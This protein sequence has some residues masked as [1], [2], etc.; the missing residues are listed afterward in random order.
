MSDKLHFVDF[1]T[2]RVFWNNNDRLKLVGH[3]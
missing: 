1:L 3:S 2:E